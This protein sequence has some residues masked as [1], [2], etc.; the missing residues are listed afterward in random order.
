MN[1]SAI[2]AQH[3]SEAFNQSLGA[4]L[5]DLTYEVSLALGDN[6]IALVLGGGYGRGE[7]G[8]AC[9]DG[10]EVPYND[11]DLSLIVRKKKPSILP[12]L[13]SIRDKYSDRLHIHVDFSC[14]LT[15]EELSHLPHWLMWKELIEGHQTLYGPADLLEKFTPVYLKKDLPPIEAA[16]LLLNRGAGLLWALRI[17]R[18]VEPAPDQDFIPRNYQKCILSL[19]DALAI[20]C[21]CH[22]T[23]YSGREAIVIPLLRDIPDLAGIHLENDYCKALEFRFRPQFYEAGHYIEQDLQELAQKWGR[24]FLYVEKLRTGKKW[25]SLADYIRWSGIREHAQNRLKDWPR[26]LVKNLENGRFSL[27]YPREFLFR[28]L[29]GLLGLTNGSH[30]LWAE[31]SRYFMQMW[32]RYN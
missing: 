24:V 2:Y 26:N 1:S 12:R 18:G 23:A 32:E 15:I 25:T 19:G 30:E 9:I 29:P 20:A 31:H 13:N 28:Q 7:G 17:I 11:L 16:R 6:L 3:A 14:P 21:R 10:C 22:Q 27:K 8:V 4:A 5:R